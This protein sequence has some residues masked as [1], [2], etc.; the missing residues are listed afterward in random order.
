M[1]LL[2]C[3]VYKCSFLLSHLT[4]L[5]LSDDV[6]IW[7]VFVI[8]FM[9]LNASFPFPL[10]LTLSCCFNGGCLVPTA[11]TTHVP[12]LNCLT[13]CHSLSILLGILCFDSFSH[14][15]FHFFTFAWYIKPALY[16]ALSCTTT[17]PFFLVSLYWKNSRNIKTTLPYNCS[18]HPQHS[19]SPV[20]CSNNA[21]CEGWVG[22]PTF[23][24]GRPVASPFL[25][26]S[27]IAF[28]VE[29]N[30]A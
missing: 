12:S 23:S 29:I 17:L 24:W 27:V 8:Y 15:T 9:I 14:S 19:V 25:W 1:H 3:I 16:A 11:C 2:S 10:I 18:R 6:I 30:S 22:W 7:W 28:T 4:F 5:S 13:F 20:G 21:L 26:Q